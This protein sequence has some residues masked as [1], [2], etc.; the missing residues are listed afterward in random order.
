MHL[1]YFLL[2]L[3][4]AFLLRELEYNQGYDQQW[5]PA[6]KTA[7]P[8]PIDHI[9]NPLPISLSRDDSQFEL[10]R[11]ANSQTCAYISGHSGMFVVLKLQHYI[12]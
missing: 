9:R 5:T 4:R 6:R 8:K 3:G 12:N 2:P 11:R 7:L 1:I 10:V